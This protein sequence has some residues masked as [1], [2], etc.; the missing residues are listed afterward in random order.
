MEI[1]K[2]EFFK[3]GFSWKVIPQTSGR[4]KGKLTRGGIQ[5]STSVLSGGVVATGDLIP[6]CFSSDCYQITSCSV[7]YKGQTKYSGPYGCTRYRCSSSGYSYY[8]QSTYCL[9][10]ENC[11]RRVHNDACDCC[12]CAWWYTCRRVDDYA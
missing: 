6:L 2:N 9:G 12:G 10:I 8:T 4:G 7:R 1:D 3:T 5:T 11:G